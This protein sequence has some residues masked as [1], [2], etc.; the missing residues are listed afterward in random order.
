MIIDGDD[1]PDGDGDARPTVIVVTPNPAVDVTYGVDRQLIGET[2]RVRRADR[3]AGGK[4]VN[5]A[6]VLTALGVPAVTVQPVGG[7][8]GALF[9]AALDA[10]G[11]ASV[12][13]PIDGETRMTVTVD[14]RDAHPTVLAEPG[15]ALQEAEWAAVTR[16]VEQTATRAAWVVIA[17]SF[18][19][20]ITP[21][22]L[23]GMIAAVRRAGARLLIDTHGPFLSVAA[24]AEVDVVK[25]NESEA[26]DATGGAD[27]DDAAARLGAAGSAVLLSRGA[28]GAGLRR[29]DGD[30]L[31]RPAV[32]GVSGNPTGAGDAATAGFIA[33]LLADRG[34]AEALEW[35]VACGAAA[36]RGATGAE[37]DLDFLRDLIVLPT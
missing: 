31:R 10:D 18:P 30:W 3:R 11:I 17:G 8:I 9:A 28:R 12:S 4:G 34:E 7:A 16:A 33:A 19:P 13:V 29:P 23:E 24:Q 25:A 14:D 22:Q 37:F 36:V 21:S 35:A 26:I 15:P 32:P 5:V 6:R 27:G 1:D 20:G 2:V